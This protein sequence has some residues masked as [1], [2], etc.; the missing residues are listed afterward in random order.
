MK[1]HKRTS[2]MRATIVASADMI[3]KARGFAPSYSGK[4]GR[5]QQNH[6]T[7]AAVPTDT[8]AAI[9]VDPTSP[10]VAANAKIANTQASD[11]AASARMV[12]A[13]SVVWEGMYSLSKAS[14][15]E[16]ILVG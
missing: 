13:G 12:R 1:T 16:L 11:N 8:M 3:F 14:T 15:C 5:R 2:R 7:N 9:T 4:I 6:A 10:M